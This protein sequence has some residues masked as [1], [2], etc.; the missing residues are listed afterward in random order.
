MRVSTGLAGHRLPCCH[1]QRFPGLLA[2]VKPAKRSVFGR[3]GWPIELSDLLTCNG[4]PS[5]SLGELRLRLQN[6]L[7][8]RFPRQGVRGFF[9]LVYG[10]WFMVY[11]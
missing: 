4:W 2:I 7:P 10:C 8:G 1:Y 6:G 3:L 11:G 5:I 9:S